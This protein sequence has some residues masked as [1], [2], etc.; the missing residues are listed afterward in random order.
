[1][2]P[3]RADAHSALARCPRR[4]IGPNSTRARAAGSR[5]ARAA[6]RTWRGVTRA[7]RSGQ[8]SGSS[9]PRPQ[10]SSSRSRSARCSTVWIVEDPRAG[11]V[12]AGA[13]DL[14]VGEVAGVHGADLLDDRRDD[15]VGLVGHRAD[16]DAEQPRHDVGRVGD[17]AADRVGQAHLVADDPAEAVG[18]ARA[19]A[20]DVVEHGQGV[21][22][23]VVAGDA[24]VAE[25]D[26]DLLAG[27]RHPA[28]PRPRRAGPAGA[29][30]GGRPPRLATSGSA[31]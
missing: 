21:E 17:P 3:Q 1:M 27:M 13:V 11:D 22:V 12:A 19:A 30:G 26:V 10:R 14:V 5:W 31:S 28:D 8:W 2:F 6:R 23:G 7:I 29:G 18:E 16:V 20:E 9:R 24:Q 15:A 25:H 4:R